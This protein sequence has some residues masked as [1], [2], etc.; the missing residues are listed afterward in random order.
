MSA[1]TDIRKVLH[2]RVIAVSK[3]DA[4]RAVSY[5]DDEIVAFDLAPPLAVRGAEA[6]DP[7]KLQEWFDTWEGPINL[8]FDQ[9][10][11]RTAGDLAV[12]Y[13]FVHMTGRRTDHSNTDVWYR[14][15]AILIRRADSWKIVHDHQ[16]FP[17][18]MD[19]SGK[20]ASDLKP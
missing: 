17:T 4:A 5:F 13:G 3:K 18:K 14:M 11:V 9:L 2:D 7:A 6:M 20:S 12:A 16:S 19:G 15:S 8:T 10:D 1:E